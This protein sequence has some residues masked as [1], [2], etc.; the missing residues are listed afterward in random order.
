MTAL[1]GQIRTFT[2][3]LIPRED[4]TEKLTGWIARTCASYL[5]PLCV[6]GCDARIR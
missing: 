2:E 1:A 3:L 6:G 5:Q 4:N